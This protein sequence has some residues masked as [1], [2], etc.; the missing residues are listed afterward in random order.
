M[1][2]YFDHKLQEAPMGHHTLMEWHKSHS[3]LA[4]VSDTQQAKGCLTFYKEDGEKLNNAGI[5]RTIPITATAWHPIKK[6]LAVGWDN[7]TITIYSLEEKCQIVNENAPVHST[8]INF[9]TWSSSGSKLISGDA[10]SKFCT[11]F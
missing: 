3:I 2:V 10:V 5:Q 6:V 8:T 7:G 9:V 11:F 4:L 1:A